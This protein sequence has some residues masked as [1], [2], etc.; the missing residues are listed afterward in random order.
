MP[1]LRFETATSV[2]VAVS[3]VRF[4]GA[5]NATAEPAVV[6]APAWFVAYQIERHLEEAR[7]LA[8]HAGDVPASARAEATM[9]EL[10]GV[11]VRSPDIDAEVQGTE[12]GGLVLVADNFHARRRVIF[13]VDPG[14]A[15]ILIKRV[16]DRQVVRRAVRTGGYHP[17]GEIRWI[18][19]Q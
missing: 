10:L 7:R 11:V 1:D 19:G 3:S 2:D 12:E 9:A 17:A 4:H 13:E 16:D 5:T 8:A 6:Q 15:E 18:R 14:G